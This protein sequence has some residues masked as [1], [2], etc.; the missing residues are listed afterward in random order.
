MEFERY[1]LYN[2]FIGIQFSP[3]HTP[4]LIHSFIKNYCSLNAF[5]VYS[6]P[7]LKDNAI[8][9]YVNNAHSYELM[10]SINNMMHEFK[11]EVKY[12][13]FP[14]NLSYS[15][16]KLVIKNLK[17][18]LRNYLYGSYGCNPLKKR[19]AYDEAKVSIKD[20]FNINPYE[21]F[22]LQNTPR[23]QTMPPPPPDDSISFAIRERRRRVRRL[24]EYTPNPS[25]SFSIPS[26]TN[27][28]LPVTIEEI[29]DNITDES[30]IP[31]PP[32]T[33]TRLQNVRPY[34]LQLSAFSPSREIPRT[35]PNNN[36]NNTEQNNRQQTSVRPYGLQL[37]R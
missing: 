2:I 30:S 28:I 35:P 33:N 37:F 4:Y 7:T 13:Y 25:I 3:Y 16:K 31:E 14:D 27:D 22:T 29:V 36:S 5:T 21:N 8:H 24:F 19:E 26:A 12:I 32:P 10:E 17:P 34:S 11:K 1:N 23:P 20:F 18:I 15:R 9:T 6:Y